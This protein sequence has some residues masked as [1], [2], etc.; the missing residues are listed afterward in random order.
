M[1]SL[2]KSC[3]R[4]CH[5]YLHPSC[6]ETMFLQWSNGNMTD[7]SVRYPRTEPH[8]RKFC[9]SQQPLRYTSCNIHPSTWAARRYCSANDPSLLF[10]VGR[11][12]EL[13]FYIPLDTIEIISEMLFPANLLTRI[14]RKQNQNQE[15]EPQKYTINLD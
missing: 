9:L 13:R 5:N 8:C 3:V 4:I 7:C 11:L 15:K 2:P 12:T 10:S 6:S 14:L 1:K